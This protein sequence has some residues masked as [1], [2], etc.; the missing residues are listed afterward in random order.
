MWVPSPAGVH[1]GQAGVPG[2]WVWGWWRQPEAATTVGA[3]GKVWTLPTSALSQSIQTK[4]PF[5]SSKIH[6]Q[7]PLH[8]LCI[9]GAAYNNPQHCHFI[10]LHLFS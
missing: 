2:Q 6:M 7:V 8:H 9:G 1:D 5:P 4:E 10:F 3:A